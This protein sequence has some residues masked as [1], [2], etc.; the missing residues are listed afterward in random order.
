VPVREN[1][2][3]STTRSRV[4]SSSQSTVTSNKSNKSNR[5]FQANLE[6]I[7]EEINSKPTVPQPT[8]VDIKRDIQVLTL[9]DDGNNNT[10]QPVGKD[11]QDEIPF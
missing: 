4:S 10:Q 5:P 8:K 6:P 2:T 7:T 1:S 3:K 11:E 9:S